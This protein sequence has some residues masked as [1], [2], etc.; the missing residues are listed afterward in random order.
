MATTTIFDN[1]LKKHNG[2]S[3][4]GIISNTGVSV[5]KHIERYIGIKNI[6][7]VSNNIWS[8]KI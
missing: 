2:K 5:I 6:T 3:N 7:K 8:N 4:S 1:D